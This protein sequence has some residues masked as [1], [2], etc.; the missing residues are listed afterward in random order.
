MDA[1]HRVAP[2]ALAILGLLCTGTSRAAATASDEAAARKRV[3]EAIES[4]RQRLHIP[5]CSVAVVVDGRIAWARGFG[6]K[7]WGFEEAVADDTLFQAAS[8]SKPVAASGALRLVE[9]DR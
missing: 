5:G 8:I 2:A 1:W 7:R 6:V 4:A 3:E 9:Q